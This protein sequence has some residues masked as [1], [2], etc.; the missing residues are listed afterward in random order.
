MKSF[1]SIDVTPK[2]L[3]ECK[4]GEFQRSRAVIIDRV[5]ILAELYWQGRI[6]YVG[7]GFSSGIH[8]VMEPA[9]ARLPILFGPRFHNSD[10]AEELIDAGGGFSI[11]SQEEFRSVIERLMYNNDFFLQ[12]SLAATDVIHR[13][14]GSAT[15]VV[16]GILRD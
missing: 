4:D 9:I 13:N 2:L 7:G 10:A 8:N 14:I 12:S 16:R 15:R 3:S 6:A 1:E 5:G 11:S